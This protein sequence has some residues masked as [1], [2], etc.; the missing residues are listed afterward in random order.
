[1]SAPVLRVAGPDA[2]TPMA[3]LEDE[4]KPSTERIRA[5]YERVLTY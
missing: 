4:F 2:V 1:M 3:R 5:A